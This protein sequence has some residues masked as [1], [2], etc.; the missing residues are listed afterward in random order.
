[1]PLLPLLPAWILRETDA[2]NF[3]P[4]T[5]AVIEAHQRLMIHKNNPDSMQLNSHSPHNLCVGSGS[6]QYFLHG[7]LTHVYRGIWG[8]LSIY[9]WDYILILSGDI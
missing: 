2:W 6:V 1:M 7:V 5:L 3:L 8:V 4:T 9:L